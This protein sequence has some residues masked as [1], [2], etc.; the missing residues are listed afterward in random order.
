MKPIQW[1]KYPETEPGDYDLYFVTY[2]ADSRR[3]VTLAQWQGHWIA[4]KRAMRNSYDPTCIAWAR[5]EYP[6]P[7]WETEDE[8]P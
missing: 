4:I 1:N 2:L 5:I 6:E 8:V 7:F 3:Y